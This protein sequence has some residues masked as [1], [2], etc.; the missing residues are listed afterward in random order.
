MSADPSSIREASPGAL[1]TAGLDEALAGVLV[2]RCCVSHVLLLEVIGP[3]LHHLA[4]FG[5]QIPRR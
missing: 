2:R 1:P 3:R 4:T 5:E